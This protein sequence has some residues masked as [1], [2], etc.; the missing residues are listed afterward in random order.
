VATPVNWRPGERAIIPPAI[1]DAQARAL[2][3]QGWEAKKPYLRY[4]DV[5]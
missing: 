4:V 1:P 2:F 5:T 3:P